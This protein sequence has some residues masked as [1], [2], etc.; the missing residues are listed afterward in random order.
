MLFSIFTPNLFDN[1]NLIIELK[2]MD[3]IFVEII[4]KSDEFIGIIKNAN[5]NSFED[6]VVNDLY[7]NID[8]M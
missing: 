4:S 1:D 7:V 3:N 6:I 2:V 8:N 5:N